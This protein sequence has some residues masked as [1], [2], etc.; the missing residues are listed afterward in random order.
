MGRSVFALATAVAWS[1]IFDHM[2]LLVVVTK[3]KPYDQGLAKVDLEKLSVDS[4]ESYLPPR[5]RRDPNYI[6]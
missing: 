2:G 4:L 6:L 3:T 1:F 5:C